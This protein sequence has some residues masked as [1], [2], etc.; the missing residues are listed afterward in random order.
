MCFGRG[1][2]KTWAA[3][4][5]IAEQAAARPGTHWAIVAPTWRDLRLVCIE[6]SSGILRALQSGELDSFNH[7]D[8]SV[9]LKNGSQIHGYSNDGVERITG[10]YAGA[11]IEELRGMENAEKM[12][13]EHLLPT[14]AKMVQPRVFVTTTPE[15]PDL[16]LECPTQ[17][18]FRPN[19]L[20]KTFMND[21]SGMVAKVLGSTWDNVEN[22]SPCAVEE[23]K[24]R[25][26]NT[27]AGRTQL[28]GIS[29]PM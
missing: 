27:L 3:S 8:M 24:K 9:R 20:Q 19:A 4:N 12:W 16:P 26:G 28:E 7:S 13:R 5:W 29:L 2:G 14:M 22:L 21:T 10:Q 15:N 23:L 17:G 11:W 18:P 25:Y 1:A 6:G